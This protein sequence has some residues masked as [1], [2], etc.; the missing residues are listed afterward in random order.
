M[1]ELEKEKANK[2]FLGGKRENSCTNIGIVLNEGVN[3]VRDADHIFAVACKGAASKRQKFCS[4]RLEPET[5]L[6][7]QFDLIYCFP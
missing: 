7:C 6:L 5:Q 4:M 3:H 2:E 1:N